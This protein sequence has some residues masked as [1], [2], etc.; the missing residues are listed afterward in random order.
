M[1]NGGIG[2]RSNLYKRAPKVAGHSLNGGV[3]EGA[4]SGLI[5]KHGKTYVS[6]GKLYVRC[7]S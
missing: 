4:T 7:K 5:H 3:L 1:W 6:I 2:R